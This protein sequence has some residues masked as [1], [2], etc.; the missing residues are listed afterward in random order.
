MK[1]KKNNAWT[2]DEQRWFENLVHLKIDKTRE[3]KTFAC[4]RGWNIDFLH[5]SSQFYSTG[6]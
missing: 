1:R 3:T 5:E 4:L 6:E 2:Y